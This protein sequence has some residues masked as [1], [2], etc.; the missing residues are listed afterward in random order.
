MPTN[1][2]I[3]LYVPTTY[4]FDV[5]QL[6]DVD[7][8][9]PEFKELLVRLYQN[10]N[11]IILSLNLKD[12]AY[13]VNQEFVNSQLFFP[14]S[15]SIADSQ[16]TYRNVFRMVVNFGTLPNNTTKSVAHNIPVNSSFSFTR[17]YGTATNSTATSF[18]PIPYSSTTAVADNLEL[19]IDDTNVNI[20]TGADYSAY[21]ICYVILEYLKQA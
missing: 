17:I 4:N 11:R 5:A 16:P 6:Q 20:K 2:N 1:P 15:I 13:Y 21:T 7:V 14:S 19:Y 10:V 8:N 9:S 18:I 3:G 12:S